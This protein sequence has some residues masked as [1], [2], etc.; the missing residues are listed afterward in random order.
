MCEGTEGTYRSDQL[1]RGER[2]IVKYAHTYSKYYVP[3]Y[4]DTSGSI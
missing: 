1:Q 3:W 2:S 4:A